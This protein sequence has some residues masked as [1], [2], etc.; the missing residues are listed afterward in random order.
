MATKITGMNIRE[1]ILKEHSKAQCNRIVTYVGNNQ[2]RLNE[3]VHLFLTD[4]YRVV[5]RAGW[6]LK[7]Y[8]AGP[9]TPYT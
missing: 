8:C 3:L 2:Q 9:S 1:A 6:P 7:L 5:Q 4:E